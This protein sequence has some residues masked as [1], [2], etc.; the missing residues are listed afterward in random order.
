M[1]FILCLG[2]WRHF[3]CIHS[4]WWSPL[5][6]TG[7]REMWR[8]KGCGARGKERGGSSDRAR[9]SV[10]DSSGSS[11]RTSQN[12]IKKRP[13][14][15]I[16]HCC[17]LERTYARRL[18][19]GSEWR[20]GGGVPGNPSGCIRCSSTAWIILFYNIE[21]PSHD[22]SVESRSVCRETPF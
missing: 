18:T 20:L 13:F 21:A 11:S 7:K 12:I 10:S 14:V 15:W 17:P 6:P 19:L 22:V 5:F 8:I 4:P 1:S 3:S 2:A 9:W 16:I